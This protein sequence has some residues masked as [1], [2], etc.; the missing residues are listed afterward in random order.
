[1]EQSIFS[2]S[3]G[4]SE[5]IEKLHKH[6]NGRE[7]RYF[8][9]KTISDERYQKLVQTSHMQILVLNQLKFLKQLGQA[10]VWKRWVLKQNLTFKTYPA[11]EPVSMWFLCYNVHW[12]VSFFPPQT[13][14]L[15]NSVFELTQTI[16]SLSQ[17]ALS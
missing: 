2:V 5:M 11:P 4:M 3:P 13:I 9:M 16:Y 6:Q 7:I 10:S 14:D 1:M 8:Y 12:D 15:Y 17:I